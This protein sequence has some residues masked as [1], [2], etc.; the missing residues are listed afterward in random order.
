M[1]V[2]VPNMKVVINSKKCVLCGACDVLTQGAIVSQGNQ[3]AYLN[4]KANL[5]DPQT[6][7]SIKMAADTCP[8]KAI[9]I[10]P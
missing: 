2:L 3:P 1:L 6:K 7:E 8:Q 4:P 5:K 10:E 9:K